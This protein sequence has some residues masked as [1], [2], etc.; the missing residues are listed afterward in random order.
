VIT[1]NSSFDP[2]FGSRF[3]LDNLTFKRIK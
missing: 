1:F 2:E 3:A